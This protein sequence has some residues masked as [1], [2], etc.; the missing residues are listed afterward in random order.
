MLPFVCLC[1][2]MKLFLSK[3]GLKDISNTKSIKLGKNQKI[4]RHHSQ[5]TELYK[6]CDSDYVSVTSQRLSLK[7]PQKSIFILLSKKCCLLTDTD[8][9]RP[10]CKISFKKS[11]RKKHFTYKKC[12]KLFWPFPSL[13]STVA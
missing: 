2:H 6:N 10:G 7:Q 13:K 4:F 11:V 5:T 8:K 3:M 12:L 1:F 9:Q